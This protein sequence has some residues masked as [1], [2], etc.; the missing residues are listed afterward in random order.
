M[1]KE[2]KYTQIC[3]FNFL[4]SFFF[5]SHK[6]MMK[7]LHWKSAA[8]IQLL[9]WWKKTVQTKQHLWMWRVQCRIKQFV[10]IAFFAPAC[11]V[12]FIPPFFLT[13]TPTPLAEPNASRRPRYISPNRYKRTAGAKC[14]QRVY[15]PGVSSLKGVLCW[16]N[17][18][19]RELHT[20]AFLQSQVWKLTLNW[21]KVGLC[22]WPGSF[23]L[24]KL[25]LMGSKQSSM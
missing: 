10:T 6:K 19:L 16:W 25:F 17:S 13:E 20:F 3:A 24:R 9:Q 2:C 8:N 12:I 5:C 11:I 15:L 7:K 21:N 23:V 4:L 14:P 1:P 18:M 22:L